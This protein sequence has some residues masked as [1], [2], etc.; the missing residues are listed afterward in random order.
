MS[1]TYYYVGVECVFA[2][3][4]TESVRRQIVLRKPAPAFSVSAPGVYAIE[5]PAEGA[6]YP[7]QITVGEER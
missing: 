6:G 4:S 2:D 7:V 5:D 1:S 3:D